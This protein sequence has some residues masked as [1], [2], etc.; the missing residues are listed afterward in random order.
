MRIGFPVTYTHYCCPS[1]YSCY[2]LYYTVCHPAQN[3]PVG[4]IGQIGAPGL[5]VSPA[6]LALGTVGPPF[7]GLQ[8]PQISIPFIPVRP[9][10]MYT[11]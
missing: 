5:G 8:M 7:G 4:G 3:S 2:P 6:Q 10:P 9:K 1:W 11:Y